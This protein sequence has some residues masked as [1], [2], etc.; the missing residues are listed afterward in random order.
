MRLVHSGMVSPIRLSAPGW[1]LTLVQWVLPS[2]SSPKP[3]F[4]KCKD[5]LQD[6]R[7]LE[8]IAWRVWYRQNFLPKHHVSVDD[9]DDGTL[10]VHM[11]HHECTADSDS[12]SSSVDLASEY[13]LS[14]EDENTQN[15]VET[16]R[17]SPDPSSFIASQQVAHIR[18][19]SAIRSSSPKS[20]LFVSQPSAL[21]PLSSSSHA[22][23]VLGPYHRASSAPHRLGENGT[24]NE[25]SSTDS[26]QELHPTHRSS[27]N[28]GQIITTL[29][30]EKVNL[31]RS[32]TPNPQVSYSNFSSHGCILRLSADSIYP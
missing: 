29:L 7:R 24:F 17:T 12:Y 5:S 16:D 18:R 13:F 14:S 4:T 3:V 28:I 15:I 1:P 8:N 21:S 27:F 32:P 6:G 26:P 22:H 31:A 2:S 25:G 9:S 10:Q 19:S 23:V 11:S 20:G 30:P